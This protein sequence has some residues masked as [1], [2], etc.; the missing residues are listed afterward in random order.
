VGSDSRLEAPVAGGA[1]PGDE[2]SGG[3]GTKECGCC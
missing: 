2:G 3:S 1:A